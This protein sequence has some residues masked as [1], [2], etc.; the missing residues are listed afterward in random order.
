LRL[1]RSSSTGWPRSSNS[2][3]SPLDPIL[4]GLL[5]PVVSDSRC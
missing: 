5:P 1:C 2:I 4:V 3:S